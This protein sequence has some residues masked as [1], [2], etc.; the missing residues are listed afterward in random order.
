MKKT[1]LGMISDNMELFKQF[2][3]NPSFK[4]WLSDTV[5]NLAYNTEGEEYSGD[6][7]IE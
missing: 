5:F 6:V 3:D 7:R 1:V 2:T 4:K